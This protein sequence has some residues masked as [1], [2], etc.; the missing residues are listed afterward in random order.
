MFRFMAILIVVITLAT[1]GC[2]AKQDRA[3]A[4][5]EK[6]DAAVAAKFANRFIVAGSGTNLPVTEQLAAAYRK[7]TGSKIEVPKSIGSDGAI[8]A[9]R[10]GTISLG[11]VSRPLTESE[12]A[13]GLKTIRYARVGIVFAVHPS[14]REDNVTFEDILQ[15]HRAQKTAWADDS[16]IKVL[17]RNVHDSSN[18]ILFSMIPGFQQVIEESL[19]EKRWPIMYHDVEMSDALRTKAGSF[20]H[21]DTTS[22]VVFG[23]I[24]A[25]SLNGIAPTPENLRSG[26][27][28][29]VKELSF[30]YKGEL[31]D[32]AKKFVEYVLSSEGRTIIE[33]NGGV[34][35]R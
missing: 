3:P 20:G 23:G 34:G 4:K 29:W 5:Q 25:L 1:F 12:Q 7:Q 21:T 17:I 14:V 10:D 24:K 19:A 13:S 2:A 33:A 32:P 18:Q 15:M 35:I 6:T 8:K 28:P 11:L 30:L 27:Y 16:R 31:S 9:V 22:I 26:R